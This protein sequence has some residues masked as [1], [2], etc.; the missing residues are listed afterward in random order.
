MAKAKNRSK[1][2]AQKLLSSPF[3]FVNSC[4]VGLQAPIALDSEKGDS[5][6][7]HI[8]REHITQCGVNTHSM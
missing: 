4:R 8:E 7:R 6:T 2:F 5:E 1:I 3:S